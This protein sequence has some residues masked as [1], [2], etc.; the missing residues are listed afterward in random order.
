M[1]SAE[2][3]FTG[4]HLLLILLGFF[5]VI[6]AVNIALAYLAN[7][8]WTGLIVEN[9]Y[10]PSQQFNKELAKARAQQAL[11]WQPE[12]TY[13]SARGVVEVQVADKTGAPLPMKTATLNLIRPSDTRLD[14]NLTLTPDGT[15][16]FLS[17]K[18]LE[19][20]KWQARL[21]LEDATGHVMRQE[22]TFVVR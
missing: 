8:S 20:G 6:F 2:R 21:Q 10:E 14:A 4:R 15:G 19:T 13:D 17:E 7:S 11:G 5:G 12:F 1:T 16:H 22:Y 9:G 3:E 18:K